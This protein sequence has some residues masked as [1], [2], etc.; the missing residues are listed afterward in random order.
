M[1]KILHGD[2]DASMFVCVCVWVQVFVCKK[3]NMSVQKRAEV[4]E[5]KRIR[6]VAD[7][8]KNNRKKKLV[9]VGFFSNVWWTNWHLLCGPTDSV[10]TLVDVTDSCLNRRRFV[11]DVWL[12]EIVVQRIERRCVGAGHLFSNKNKTKVYVSRMIIMCIAASRL[13]SYHHWQANFSWFQINSRQTEGWAAEITKIWTK[14][15]QSRAILCQILD[16]HTTFGTSFR[17]SFTT[18]PPRC[19]QCKLSRRP[20]GIRIQTC[21]TCKR[22]NYIKNK[23]KSFSVEVTPTNDQNRNL[24]EAL[25][26]T[27][28][29]GRVTISCSVI[30]DMRLIASMCL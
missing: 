1:M 21:R 13:T 24:V 2:V 25:M 27:Q 22:L 8:K 29:L 17:V 15:T 6:I 19:H 30:I 16:G 11:D 10:A 9:F 18:I 5:K 26:D 4:R 14:I 23:Q 7:E 28:D 3:K 12:V 20:V